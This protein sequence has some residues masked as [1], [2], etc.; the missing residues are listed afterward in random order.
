MR[1]PKLD[2]IIAPLEVYIGKMLIFNQKCLTCICVACKCYQNI[3]WAL[4]SSLENRHV[5]LVQSR[6]REGA[7]KGVNEVY[8]IKIYVLGHL[9]QFHCENWT[10]SATFIK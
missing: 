5:G 9:N 2:L 6:V 1:D 7:Q 8:F 10:P 4:D 3:F